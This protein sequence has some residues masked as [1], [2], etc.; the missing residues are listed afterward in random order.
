MKL[1]VHTPCHDIELEAAPKTS[2]RELFQDLCKSLGIQ[3]NWWFGLAYKGTENEDVWIDKSKKSLHHF[4][5]SLV[6]LRFMVKF[7]PEDVEELIETITIEYFFNHV[8]TFITKDV[9]FCAADTAVL[10]A[11]Y[12]LQAKHG[13]YDKE[14]FNEDFFKKQ[15]FL[16]DRV[17]KQHKMDQTDWQNNITGMWVKHRGLD[18]EEAMMEYLKLVQNLEMYGV[19]Y[20]DIKNVKGTDLQLGVTALGLDMYKKEDK[21]NPSTSFPW[22][23]IKNLK[24]KGTKFIIKPTDKMAKKFA[25]I[26]TS[27]RISKIILSLGI[28]NHELY[29]RRRKPD[30]PD[31]V[32]MKEKANE[33]R[34][35]KVLI[36]QKYNNERLAREEAERRETMYKQQLEDLKVEL[37]RKNANMLD[38]ERTIRKLQHQLDDLKRSKE[39]LESQ[40]QELQAMMS[41]LEEIKNM[42]A[43]EKLKL[44][45]DI[46]LKH[47]E[48]QRIQIEVSRKD[49]ETRRLQEEVELA[50][51]REEEILRQQE[52]ERR[53]EEER[54]QRELERSEM[55]R[56]SQIEHELEYMP[57]ADN[58]LPEYKHVKS[59]LNDPI[60]QLQMQLEETRKHSEE[61]ELDRIHRINLLE[62]RDKF[63]TL[64]DI[65][66]GNTSRRVEMFENM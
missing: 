40:K 16:P 27:E 45:E 4:Q 47:E 23:E 49:E 55:E 19:I 42:E 32:K 43:A 28:G 38:A 7:Y 30:T 25:I 59:D 61:T 34:K 65:R 2:G 9:I 12:A 54:R 62:G 60:K 31:V 26:T 20:F 3:E 14:N 5:K 41:R 8:K 11:S 35:T 56:A 29:I 18:K 53:L 33:V 64:R 63:K 66:K 15:T 17:L 44:E 52:E 10:L 58:T 48:V 6:N 46:R 39:E 57:N 36:R 13:D 21:L 1:T 24:I 50:R 37:E 51:K 22:S